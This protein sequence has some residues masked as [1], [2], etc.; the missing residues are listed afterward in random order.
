MDEESRCFTEAEIKFF[1]E[2]DTGS[3]P[4]IVL[5]TKFDALYDDEFVELTSK[6]VSRKDAQAL[7]SQ[8]ARESFDNGPQVKMLYNCEGNRRPPKCH[9]CLPD[10]AKDD[11]DCGPLI[12]RTAE[13]LD[14]RVLKQLFVS[15]QQTNLK[16]C[17]IYAIKSNVGAEIEEDGRF[18]REEEFVN[19]LV[20]WFPHISNVRQLILPT[21]GMLSEDIADPLT[22]TQ[23]LVY[24]CECVHRPSNKTLAD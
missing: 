20:Q 11:A 12:E 9:V 13:I 21:S 6:G 8:Q 19:D 7:A 2:C 5:F 10:M 3:I 17:M 1:S 23:E 15:T 22:A 16:L 18:Y 24:V 4:V 14:D